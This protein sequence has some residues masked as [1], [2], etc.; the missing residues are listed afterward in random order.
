M[1]DEEDIILSEARFLLTNFCV[2]IFGTG[3]PD[4][5][6]MLEAAHS[7]GDMLH[8]LRSIAERTISEYADS[9]NLLHDTVAEINRTAE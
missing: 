9:M 6:D 7:V 3:A 5:L 8:C 4:L 2:D 1:A